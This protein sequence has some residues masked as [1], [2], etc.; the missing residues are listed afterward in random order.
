MTSSAGATNEPEVIDFLDKAPEV[1]GKKK[2]PPKLT[3]D[4]IAA[5]LANAGDFFAKDDGEELYFFENGVYRP[6]GDVYVRRR[7]KE[8]HVVEAQGGRW[9]QAAANETVGWLLADAPQ[10]LKRPPTEFLN[11]PNGMLEVETRKLRPHDPS[12]LSPVQL[13]CEFNPKATCPRWDKFCR[14]VLPDDNRDVLYKLCA[15]LM[16]PG[17]DQA[18]AVLLYGPQGCGK[19]RALA[20][21]T[22]FLGPQ[23]VSGISLHTL[24]EGRFSAAGLYGRLANIFSDLPRRALAETSTFKTL[25]GGDRVWVERKFKD[26]FEFSSFARLV[27]SANEAP[28]TP[29]TSDAYFI[30]WSL[31][32]FEC[33]FRGTDRQIPEAE[34]DAQLA[35]P[36]ELSGVLNRALELLPEVRAHGL[37]EPASSKRA[38]KEFQAESDPIAAWLDDNAVKLPGVSVTKRA[39]YEAYRKDLRGGE[40][41]PSAKSFALAV[42]RWCP[43]VGETRPTVEGGRALSWGGVGL[44]VDEEAR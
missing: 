5:A 26:G 15:K 16:V 40:A 43:G 9:R 27:F 31:I 37:G 28:R 20:A 22:N 1:R 38:A 33:T 24:E 6:R 25:T 36:R 4:R 11:L 41:K 2:E 21:V 10:L 12:F 34:L 17:L 18:R 23:N 3:P 39:L 30:R 44:A 32:P 7:V 8:Q 35:D 19:S 42:R 14:D 13:G 29:D